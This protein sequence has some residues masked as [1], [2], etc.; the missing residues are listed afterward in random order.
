MALSDDLASK[1]GVLGTSPGAYRAR[2]CALFASHLGEPPSA[3]LIAGD[4]FTGVPIAL[5]P[6][7]DAD[8]GHILAPESAWTGLDARDDIADKPLNQL[9]SPRVRGTT[10]TAPPRSPSPALTTPA[11]TSR[12]PP[13]SRRCVAAATSTPPPTGPPC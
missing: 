7:T 10:A 3:P 11:R 9:V 8:D 1:H 4:L 12:T 5:V 13:F 2:V 6:A